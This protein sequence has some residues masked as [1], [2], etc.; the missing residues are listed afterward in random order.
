MTRCAIVGASGYTGA[1]LVAILLRHPHA[2]IVGMFGSAKE[3]PARC[4]SDLHPR[5]RGECDLAIEPA[6]PETILA[7]SPDAVFL[8][9]P[10]E[11]SATIASQLLETDPETVIL[12]L[13]AAFRLPVA[14]DYETF[15]GFTHP[16]PELLGKAVYGL[17]ERAGNALRTAELVAV[18]GCYPTSVILPLAPLVEAGAVAAG[19]RPVADCI[20]GVS[21]AGRTPNTRNMFGEV[22]VQPYGV[23][24]HRHNPEIRTYTDADV[25]F[26][27]HLGPYERGIVSTIHAELAAGWDEDRVRTLLS[28]TYRGSRCVRVLPAGSWPSVNSVRHTNFCDIGLAVE[29]GHLILVSAIDNLIKGASGQAVQCMNVRFGHDETAGLMGNGAS[30]AA[31]SGVPS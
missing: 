2:E 29:R 5:F 28:D 12:D 24:T 7:C 25:I 3:G 10:H 13:S 21:G 19:T 20:S 30:A 27:P 6:E 8:C 18:P 14:G 23:W 11:V 15:Y 16:A 26:T 22:S 1:E 31:A 17:V 9:T 4:F